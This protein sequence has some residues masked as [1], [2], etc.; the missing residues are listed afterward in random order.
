MQLKMLVAR[1]KSS[2]EAFEVWYVLHFEFLNTGI[3]RSDYI[4][5]LTSLFGWKYQKNSETIYEELYKKQSI[6]IKNAENLLKQYTPHIPAQDNPATTVHL[7]V[8]EL[9]KFIP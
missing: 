9:N 2:H 5:K 7:L 8:Q 6:A 3:P 4:K 1:V